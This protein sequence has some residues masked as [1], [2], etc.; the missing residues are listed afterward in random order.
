[1]TQSAWFW[2]EVL[3]NMQ[4]AEAA[5]PLLQELNPRVRVTADKSNILEKEQDFYAQFDLVIACDLDFMTTT[6]V[7]AGCRVAQ[8]P[9]YAA[10]LHGFYGY[11]FADLIQHEYII[12]RGVSNVAT[13]L[14]AESTTRSIINVTTKKENGKNIE[15]VTKREMYS[16]LLLANTSPLPPDYMS[17]RRKM[18]SVTPLLPA[19]RALWDFE[20]K[21]NRLP[22]HSK[23]DLIIYTQLA[24]DKLLELQMPSDTLKAEFLRSFLQNIGSELVPVAAFVGGRLSEDVINVLGKR[25]QPLQNMAFFDGENFEGPIYA[26]HPIFPEMDAST[27]DATLAVSVVGDGMNLGNGGIIVL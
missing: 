4:R 11:I 27:T 21:Y 2:T 26:L 13:T 24:N 25:E 22:S 17:N 10:G 8:R 18:K 7:N 19:M 3:T 5:T 1:M 15:L 6:Q 14:K 9:F 20:R 12:E 23:E 16:P